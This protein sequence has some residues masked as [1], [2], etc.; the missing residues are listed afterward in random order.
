VPVVDTEPRAQEAA[1]AVSELKPVL[2]PT[3]CKI[4]TDMMGPATSTPSAIL[5]TEIAIMSNADSSQITGAS[6]WSP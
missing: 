2:V 3:R 6:P 1:F 5:R 4:A